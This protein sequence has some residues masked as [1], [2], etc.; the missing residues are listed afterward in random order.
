MCA[1]FFIRPPLHLFTRK[2]G[3]FA[4]AIF[5]FFLRG[6]NDGNFHSYTFTNLHSLRNVGQSKNETNCLLT[7]RTS[8]HA[9]FQTDKKLINNKIRNHYGQRCQRFDCQPFF[10]I[11]TIG[12][13]GVYRVNDDDVDFFFNEQHRFVSRQIVFY[14]L[15]TVF[16]LHNLQFGLSDSI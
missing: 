15:C 5:F 4:Y 16:H 9:R 2:Y 14:T 7:C 3:S 10:V 11:V 13:Y 12:Y 1:L 8:K 6:G